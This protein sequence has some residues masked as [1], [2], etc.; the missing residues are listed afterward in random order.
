MPRTYIGQ[1]PTATI[2]H[3]VTG[4]WIDVERGVPTDELDDLDP[5]VYDLGPE[6]ETAEAVPTPKPAPTP[7]PAPKPAPTP[8]VPAPK[9]GDA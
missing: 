2:Q 9:D 8:P 7:A 5:E 3:P 4:Q 6:W 1:T